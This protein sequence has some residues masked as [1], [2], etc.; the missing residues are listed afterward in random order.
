MFN[1]YFV[2]VL[3]ILL[4]VAY[5]DLIDSVK[6]IDKSIYKIQNNTCDIHNLKYLFKE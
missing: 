3:A 4:T 2:I 5:I 1:R 6:R